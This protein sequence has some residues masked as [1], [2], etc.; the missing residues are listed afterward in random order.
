MTKKYVISSKTSAKKCSIQHCQ[1]PFSVY[2]LTTHKTVTNNITRKNFFG[3]VLP[4][5][6]RNY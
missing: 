5:K 1:I 2:K 3:L 6:K 4:K